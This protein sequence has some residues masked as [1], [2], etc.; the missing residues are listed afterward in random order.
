METLKT[1]LKNYEKFLVD[2]K[3][4]RSKHIPYMGRWVE[5]FLKFS[6]KYRSEPF[7]QVLGRFIDD[8]SRS[9]ALKDWQIGQ[10]RDA[11]TIYR[12]QFR[13]ESRESV[14]TKKIQPDQL[15]PKAILQEVKEVARL[16]H[17]SYSTE[18]TYV[19]WT[20]R[21][22]SFCIDT[23]IHPSDS[24]VKAFLTHLALDR[25]VSA[26]TQNQAFNALLFACRAVLNIN[27][28]DMDKTVRARRRQRIPTVLSVGEVKKLLDAI[29]PSYLLMVK[30][31]YGT[32]LRLNELLSLRVKDIDF[33]NGVIVVRSGKGDKDRTT[34]LPG[35]I[36]DELSSHIASVKPL[37]DADLQNGNGAVY[38][39][40]ALARKYPN[41]STDWGWQYVFPAEKHSVDPRSGTV[42]RH[43][44]YGNTLQRAIK[45]AVAK[46]GIV[47]PA[48]TH[49]LRH[50]FAT[51]LLLGGTDI[52]EIQELLGHKSLK[53]TMVYTHVVQDLRQ[54]SISPLDR[55]QETT[56]APDNQNSKPQ[57]PDPSVPPQR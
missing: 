45:R 39:P 7:E 1:V 53:T 12:Y 8:L 5:K 6:L 40:E 42:R 36:C 43:H 51:H 41:A 16:R 11:I 46:A 35:S 57:H 33:D 47:K 48:S 55:L 4:S 14:Q 52:R 28:I 49:T 17:Y 13:H 2:R 32:G 9:P 44:L 27:L 29:E 20:R 54:K 34:V 38:L 50:S 22:L 26:S 25:R 21:F 3:L 19:Y 15:N 37:H 31:L 30:L 23:D 24:T 10:A 56:Q 18:K